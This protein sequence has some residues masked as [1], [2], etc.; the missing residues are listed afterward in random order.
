[1]PD[2]DVWDDLLD[3]LIADTFTVTRRAQSTDPTTGRVVIT[4]TQLGP[5]MGTVVPAARLEMGTDEQ[6]APKRISVTSSFALQ[7][8]VAGY[9]PDQVIWAGD[10]YKVVEVENYQRFGTGFTQATCESIDSQDA[11]A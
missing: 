5:F 1:M 8:V 10:V 2:L 9:F 3:P 11:V 7:G 4:T 6:H